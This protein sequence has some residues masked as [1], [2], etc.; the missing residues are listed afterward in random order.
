MSGNFNLDVA[1]TAG[2]WYGTQMKPDIFE[3]ATAEWAG[4]AAK[5]TGWL[6]ARQGQTIFA[7]GNESSFIY[8]D[9]YLPFQEALRCKF[10][11]NE[12][13]GTFTF[14]FCLELS[15]ATDL[16]V[17][18]GT[19]RQDFGGVFFSNLGTFEGSHT[20]EGWKKHLVYANPDWF[21]DSS[22]SIGDFRLSCSLNGL[23]TGKEARFAY[24]SL[25][26]FPRT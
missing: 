10:W 9:E 15:A 23:S 19:I 17:V 5:N 13:W 3:P 24:I 8:D 1:N 7:R 18:R 2:S 20:T 25:A 21:K 6:F 12:V 14:R 4:R 26:G 22:Q 11:L 16:L